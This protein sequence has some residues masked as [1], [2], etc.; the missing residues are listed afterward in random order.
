MSIKQDQLTRRPTIELV[1]KGAANPTR[2]G[3]TA[4][5]LA[6]IRVDG[7]FMFLFWLAVR[8]SE[9][10]DSLRELWLFFVFIISMYA[11]EPPQAV[12]ISPRGGGQIFQ[13]SSLAVFQNEGGLG[14][15]NAQARFVCLAGLVYLEAFSAGLA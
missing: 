9:S 2:L 10:H 5:V 11:C 15:R 4:D 7:A 6:G 1:V 13:H 14:R 3:K 12:T 8:R